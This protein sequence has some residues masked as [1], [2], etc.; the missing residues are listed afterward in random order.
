MGGGV[1]R[2]SDATV[3]CYVIEGDDG[4]VMVDSGWPRS[5]PRLLES[6][7]EIGIAPDDLQAVVLTHGDPDHVGCAT[8]LQQAHGATLYAHPAERSRVFG[9][10]YEVP[11]GPITANL[12]RPSTFRFVLGAL[13][14]GTNAVT[15]PAEVEFSE[16]LPGGLEQVPTP[17]HTHGHCSYL[18]RRNGMFFAGDA[19]LTR[20]IFTGRTGPQ[21]HPIQLN[22]DA[23]MR[24]LAA[25]AEVPADVLL[26]GHGKAWKGRMDEAASRAEHAA[27]R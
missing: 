11:T 18:L 17:G 5:R 4:V 20:N 19:L 22:P 14:R 10:S 8:W 16:A 7:R 24:A 12:W 6:F 1:H 9:K 25:M 27:L 21:L 13:R 26:P 15:W 23:G 2:I 3:N